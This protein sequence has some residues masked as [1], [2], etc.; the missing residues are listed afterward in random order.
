MLNRAR[1]ILVASLAIG[2]AVIALAATPAVADDPVVKPRID[3]VLHTG[4]K[5]P[6]TPPGGI[7]ICEGRGFPDAVIGGR[8]K[9]PE[10]KEGDPPPDPRKPA[11]PGPEVVNAKLGNRTVTVLGSQYGKC[12]VSVPHD[13]K[14]GNY[15]LQIFVGREKSNAVKVQVLSLEE[16]KKAFG[17]REGE[18]TTSLENHFEKWK[19]RLSIDKF[20]FGTDPKSGKRIATVEGTGKFPDRTYVV[21]QLKLTRKSEHDARKVKNGVQKVKVNDAKFTAEFG[22]FDSGFLA[23]IYQVEAT[24]DPTKNP[25]VK[26]EI[27]SMVTA[28]E[29]QVVTGWKKKK[30]TAREF[31]THGGEEERKAEGI[32]IKQHYFDALAIVN[33][34]VEQLDLAY[35]ST[36]K[37]LFKQGSKYDDA[38]W[39]EHMKAHRLLRRDRATGR[40]DEKWLARIRDD[41]R[42]LTSSYHFDPDKYLEWVRDEQI[43]TIAALQRKH[44]EYKDQYVALRFPEASLKLEHMLSVIFVLTQKRSAE[45]WTHNEL[46]IPKEIKGPGEMG[47]LPT[48]PAVSVAYIRDSY[49]EIVRMVELKDWSPPTGEGEDEGGSDD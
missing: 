3:Q 46:P 25:H 18:S 28:G 45:F 7:L 16:F 11:E 14:P 5:V 34:L 15:D 39:F 33:D 21:L 9:P 49:H 24:V 38:K 26:K 44:T 17:D 10:P 8:A 1:P 42:F 13:M 37:S 30:W 48:T 4:A 22:P 19:K 20:E 12:T 41:K 36:A 47:P 40:W 31:L 35:A 6:S 27:A 29:K 43:P 23:G 2:V 32:A